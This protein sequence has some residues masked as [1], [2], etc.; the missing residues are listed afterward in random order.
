MY[1]F[2]KTSGQGEKEKQGSASGN[3]TYDIHQYKSKP[4]SISISAFQKTSGLAEKAKQDH[5]SGNLTYD[6]L[7]YKSK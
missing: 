1:A 7:Q 6:I 3:N 2:Q 4:R 5:A